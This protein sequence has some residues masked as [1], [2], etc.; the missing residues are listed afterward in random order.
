MKCKNRDLQGHDFHKGAM[1]NAPFLSLHMGIMCDV[2]EY[3]M[4][5]LKKQA[6]FLLAVILGIALLP[7]DAQA[8]AKRCDTCVGDHEFR[9]EALVLGTG[10]HLIYNVETGVV[11]QWNVPQTNEDVDPRRVGTKAV[12]VPSKQAPPQG[13]ID[14]IQAAHQVY[15]AAGS[16][17]ADI[18]VDANTLGPDLSTGVNAFDFMLDANL[19]AR[20]VDMI[21]RPDW[22]NPNINKS[23]FAT[24]A[25]L[26]ALLQSYLGLRANSSITI[27]V[28]YSDGST[29]KISLN[30]ATGEVKFREGSAR[31]PGGQLIP[32]SLEEQGY[33]R[34][35]LDSNMNEIA[36]YFAAQGA[37]MRYTGA[38]GA[39]GVIITII[40]VK[41]VCTV[42]T[43]FQ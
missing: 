28:K 2:M 40:C 36:N 24:V 30:S 19:R 33:W 17:P 29:V 11:Q 27:T 7:A 26:R 16:F 18:V 4:H 32:A 38:G 34:G 23:V 9:D 3:K 41:N 6:Y 8:T 20:T 13:A 25:H 35:E 21:G 5:F 39:S 37:T 12:G 31:T 15:L 1:I 43:A 14:E 42:E 22:Q 10:V